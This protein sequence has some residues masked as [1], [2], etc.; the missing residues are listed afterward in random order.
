VATDITLMVTDASNGNGG[1]NGQV[2]Y[3]QDVATV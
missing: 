2:L 1:A 3:P